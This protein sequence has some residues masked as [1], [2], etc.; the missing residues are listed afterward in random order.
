MWPKSILLAMTA[1]SVALVATAAAML[2]SMDLGPYRS[3]VAGRI[4]TA[5]GRDLTLGG[6]LH[7]DVSLHPAIVADDLALANASWGSRP[8]MVTVRRLEAELEL[9]PL[10][11]G[12]IRIRRVALI[13]VDVLLETDS[14]GHGNWVMGKATRNPARDTAVPDLPTVADL[15]I[16]DATLAFREGESGTTHSIKFRRLKAWT[17][18]PPGRIVVALDGMIDGVPVSLSGRLGAV[19]RLL[20]G[21][22]YP[23]DLEGEIAGARVAIKG[24]AAG[25][26]AGGDLALRISLAGKEFADLETLI[27]IALPALGPYSVAVTL[28]RL[29]AESLRVESLAAKIGGSDLGGDLTIDWSGARPRIEA[30]LTSAA[31]DLSDFR[32][33][34]L[35]SLPHGADGAVDRLFPADPL[36]FA[37]LHRVDGVV[38]IASRRVRWR[39]LTFGNARIKASLEKDRLAIECFEADWAGGTIRVAVT[40]DA[41]RKLPVLDGRVAGRH[42][43]VGSLV[44]TLGLTDGVKGGAA[45]FDLDLRGRGEDLR[46]IM[47]GLDGTVRLDIGPG[48]VVGRSGDI[49]LADTVGLIDIDE[50][51]DA[52]NLHCVA[53]RFAIKDGTAV[54]R[55]LVIDTNSA[56]VI[57]DGQVDLETETLDIHLEP[58]AKQVSFMSFGTP[59]TIDG[60]LTRPSVAADTTTLAVGAAAAAVATGATGGIAGIVAALIASG[61]VAAEIAAN[62]GSEEGKGRCDAILAELEADAVEPGRSKPLKRRPNR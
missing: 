46:T 19:P 21:A 50:R 60:T 56:V 18:G 13:G 27:G 25:A 24:Q 33:R 5:I 30:D 9:L 3:L 49:A 36:P 58:H 54:S 51:L 23:V 45:D 10:L 41:T 59:L 38:E 47:A 29:D 11:A 12:E 39:P 16:K 44:R 62:D 28:R 20:S 2:R 35:L 1:L 52:P 26:G 8:Q 61:A 34:P 6:G 55:G 14:A 42:I 32:L 57:G 53:G 15:V 43:V 7:L 17:D 40:V 22:S 31:L 4:E 48:R 37:W